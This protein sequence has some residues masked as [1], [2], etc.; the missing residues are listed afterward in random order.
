MKKKKII[1][2][3][4]KRI[5]N[6]IKDIEINALAFLKLEINLKLYWRLGNVKNAVYLIYFIE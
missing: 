2:K 6:C 4:K 3:K 5:L 1:K